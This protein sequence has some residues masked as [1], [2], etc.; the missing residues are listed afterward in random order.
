MAHSVFWG[1]GGIGI[2]TIHNFWEVFHSG[3]ITVHSTEVESLSHKDVVNLKNG[4]AVATNIIIHCTG[5]DKGY[6]TFSQ[7]LQEDLGLAY[8]TAQWSKWK[9]LDEKARRQVD[10]LFPYLKYPP[11]SDHGQSA[12]ERDPQGPNR[13]YRRLVVPELAANGDRSILF[14]GHIHSAFTPLAAELQAL[15]GVT[16]MLGWRELPS[17]HDMEMEAALFNAW[18]AKR[19]LEQGKKH[20]YFIYDYIAVSWVVFEDAIHQ[21]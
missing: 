13:H 19:Y 14:P 10:E 8:D 4:Y 1:S 15:W 11:T 20:S 5:F 18:T 12:G 7:Q 6:S 16:W 17:Q 2:A 21:Y 3:D 9:M